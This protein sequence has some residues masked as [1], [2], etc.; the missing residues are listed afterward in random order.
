MSGATKYTYIN[1]EAPFH[2]VIGNAG[3]W[4]HEKWSPQPDWSAHRELEY[5]FGRLNVINATHIHFQH[6]RH[7]DN[8]VSDE[9]WVIK[10]KV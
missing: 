7:H 1:P 5:G 2:L 8:T 9:L 4:I 6:I 3:A 10:N